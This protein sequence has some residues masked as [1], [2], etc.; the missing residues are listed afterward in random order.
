MKAAVVPAIHGKW[1]VKEIPTPKPGANQVL[2]KIHA[3]GLCY[4]D[5]HITEGMLPTQFPRTLG[6]EPVG[7][8]VEMGPGVR[9]RKTGDRVGVPWVQA[10][11]GRCE[12]CLRGKPNFCAEQVATGIQ[13]QGSHA[14][15]MVAYADST[16]LLPEGLSYEQAAPIFCAGYTVWSGLRW[17]HPRPHERIAVLGI[18]GLG[19]LGLQ[20]SRAAGFETV[21]IT[22]SKDKEKFIRE[23]GADEVVADGESLRA[24]GGADVIL[25]TSNSY[26]ATS[27]ALKG[28]R[29]DGRLVLMGASNETLEVTAELIFTRGRI[30]G[31]TQNQPEYLF[32][33]LDY[34]AKGKVKVI[35]E[36]YKLDDIGKAY[37]RVANGKVRFRAVITN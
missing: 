3:S 10:S 12:W 23:L 25:A 29:P 28:L 13:T 9:T 35:E 2:I 34:A 14:E 21:A 11:C 33:A 36:T 1:E 27:N 24:A 26:K 22:H 5:V 7:E 15:Y 8:V 20:Y 17:A 19:H 30:L 31:S 18:G 6:H 32:E 37:D 16:M 4:T